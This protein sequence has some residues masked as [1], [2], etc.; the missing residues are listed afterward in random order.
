MN[1]VDTNFK[2]YNALWASSYLFS[3]SHWAHYSII[4][5]LPHK[6]CLEIGPGTKPKIPVKDNYFLDISP[7]A[8]DKLNRKGAIA[9]VSDLQGSLPFSDNFFDLVCAFELLEHVPADKELLIEIRRVLKK[10]SICLLSFPINMKFWNDF[11]K[12]A[13]HVRRYD[14][15]K[16]SQ[17]FE[18]TGFSIIQYATI[19]SPWPSKFAGKLLSMLSK[20]SPKLVAVLQDFLDLLPNASLRKPLSLKRWSKKLPPGVYNSSTI[21]LLLKVS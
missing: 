5:A 3:P 21:F 8:V 14:P 17:L 4:L 1:T 20:Y 6:R 12:A 9:K 10:G 13:G 16:L 19:Q 15:D 18:D 2:H 11:D 7:V